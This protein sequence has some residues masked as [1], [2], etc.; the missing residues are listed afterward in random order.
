MTT[1]LDT[2]AFSYN[3][4]IIGMGLFFL[5]LASGGET[6]GVRAHLT[7]TDGLAKVK[8]ENGDLMTGALLTQQ[9]TTVTTASIGNS[10]EKYINSPFKYTQQNI[11]TNYRN[12]P[13]GESMLLG[14]YVCMHAHVLKIGYA[15]HTKCPL[16]N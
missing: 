5:L 13:L 14:A 1:I 7:D 16:T 10:R 11:R 4:Y 2:Y 8:L 15:D 6:E 3:Y 12:T 9:A